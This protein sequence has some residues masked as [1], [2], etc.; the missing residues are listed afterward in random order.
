MPRK[1]SPAFFNGGPR[2]GRRDSIPTGM[3]APVYICSYSAGE[4]HHYGLT[5]PLEEIPIYDYFGVCSHERE[6]GNKNELH[7]CLV[8]ALL[9]HTGEH[10]CCC[11]L[12][13]TT[14]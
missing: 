6:C 13:W 7:S 2:G 12:K 1:L 8:F 3:N 11:G 14:K 5:N 9:P 10:Q 4:W